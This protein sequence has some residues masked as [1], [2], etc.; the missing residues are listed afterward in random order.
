MNSY[1]FIIHINRTYIGYVI[2]II[3][4]EWVFIFYSN[5]YSFGNEFYV[6]K[7]R[8]TLYD[9]SVFMNLLQCLGYDGHKTSLSIC[10]G[11]TFTAFPADLQ[12]EISSSGE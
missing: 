10:W 8:V 11:I 12:P 9:N 5:F 2:N 1:P 3:I 7:S 4:L 6:Q